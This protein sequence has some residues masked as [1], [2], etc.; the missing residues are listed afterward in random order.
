M[1]RG[2]RMDDNI[3]L[4]RAHAKKPASLDYLE[5]LVHHRCGIDGD[6]VSH[7]PVGMR[8]SLLG[9]D[10]RQPSEERLSKRTAGRGQNHPT[11]FSV[12]SAAEEL[13]HSI[14]L[15]VHGKECPPG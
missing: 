15:A 13:M 3:H 14:L 7:A 12:Y 1:N 4:V 2:L 9:S 10:V 11:N 6:A 8:E 5:T